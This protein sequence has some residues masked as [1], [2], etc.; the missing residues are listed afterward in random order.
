MSP[1]VLA[2]V[3]FFV[4]TAAKVCCVFAASRV[5]QAWL[6]SRRVGGR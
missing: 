6:L 4:W 2:E 3:H 5:L 1:A